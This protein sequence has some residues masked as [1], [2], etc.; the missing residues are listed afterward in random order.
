LLTPLGPL[1]AW[2]RGDLT[3]VAQRLWVAA[4]V[5]AAAALAA[6]ALVRP[7]QAG[8]ALG[9][10]LGAWLITGALVEIAERVRLFRAP[11]GEVGRRTT[12]LP[13][14]A[15]GTTLAHAGL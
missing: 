5:A 2:K 15:W 6:L 12:G 9:V 1:L 7:A 13:R 3:G 4:A 14:G 10:G 8:A 11:W